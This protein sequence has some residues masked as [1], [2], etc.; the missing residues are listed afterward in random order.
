MPGSPELAAEL[1]RRVRRLYDDASTEL[2]R[3]VAREVVASDPAVLGAQGNAL[4]RLTRD[5]DRVI[6]DLQEDVPGA[7]DD[8][9]RTAYGRGVREADVDAKRAGV[10]GALGTGHGDVRAVSALVEDALEPHA[11]AILQL[12][13]S[14]PDVYQRVSTDAASRVLIGTTTRQEAARGAVRA[15]A[16]KGVSQFTDQGGRRWEI[17]AYAEM[18]TRT[19]TGHAAVAAHMGRLQDLG[20]DLVIISDAPEE[21]E[22]CRPWEGQVLSLSGEHVGET[23]SDGVRVVGSMAEAEAA[24]LYHPNCRHSQS[25]YI[26]GRTT[27]PTDTADPDGDAERQRQRAYERRIREWKR[28]AAADEETLGKTS[29]EAKATRKKLRGVQSEF[30]SWR[31]ETGRRPVTGRTNIEYR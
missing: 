24:G 4:A 21:C 6:L 26:P 17:G 30:K 29:P 11:G 22:I 3:S 15:L 7:V 27:R 19:T 8:A 23:L 25:I 13:R 16:D 10:T 28:R 2:L 31:D 18:A 9:I 20:Q 14:V 5:L 12:R 1:A